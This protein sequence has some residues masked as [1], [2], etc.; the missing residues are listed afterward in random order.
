MNNFKYQFIFINYFI[1]YSV[2]I[3][4]SKFG[5][6]KYHRGHHVEGAWVFGGIEGGA[7]RIFIVVVENRS[8]ETLLQ[9]I[10]RFV[11]KGTTIYSDC[12]KRY[13]QLHQHP[14][15]VHLQVNHSITFKDAET[16]VHTNSIEASWYIIFKMYNFTPISYLQATC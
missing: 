9:C 11:E 1:N 2:E 3:D 13:S 12:W 4:E 10:E 5:K 6:R 15:Y 14:N 7:G 16:G 8:A